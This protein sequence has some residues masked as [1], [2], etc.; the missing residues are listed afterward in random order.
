[1]NIPLFYEKITYNNL[2]G[3]ELYKSLE[4]IDISDKMG[5][6]GYIDFLQPSD[7]CEST[8]SKNGFSDM[9]KP[10][11]VKGIDRYN[12]H[13]VALKCKYRY[14]DDHSNRYSMKKKWK[15]CVF[16]IFQRYT[17]NEYMWV[18]GGEI[19]INGGSSE[20]A[21]GDK[22]NKLNYLL[23]NGYLNDGIK[24]FMLY[25]VDLP[26]SKRNDDMD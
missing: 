5:S 18:I 22:W 26:F 9:D 6:T 1:M 7:I 12:R 20:M 16:T 11:M 14:Y 3:K 2:T 10:K 25:T 13:F 23:R 19:Q 15:D 17:H 24:E 21:S 8:I 4:T